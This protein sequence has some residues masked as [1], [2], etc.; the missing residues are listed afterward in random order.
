MNES[1]FFTHIYPTLT[2]AANTHGNA[3]EGVTLLEATSEAA[4]ELL[5]DYPRCVSPVLAAY[6]RKLSKALPHDTL[7]SL[8]PLI[9]PLSKTAGDGQDAAREIL[10]FDWLALVYTPAWLRLVTELREDAGRLANL[11]PIRNMEDVIRATRILQEVGRD[12][13]EALNMSW[14]ASQAEGVAKIKAATMAQATVENAAAAA[15]EII[16]WDASDPEAR[17]ANTPRHTTEAV[18]W[19]VARMAATDAAAA[20]AVRAVGA[21]H[22]PQECLTPLAEKLQESAVD[23]LRQ[24]I[25]PSV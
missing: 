24:M 19:A 6:A 12:A 22:D 13:Y 2:I 8:K 15:S 20:T 4:G 14:A 5:N 21:G 23:L 7:Q 17:A 3:A 18:A 11:P 25:N 9:I 1:D 16:V 10:A